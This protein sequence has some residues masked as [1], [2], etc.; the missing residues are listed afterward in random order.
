MFPIDLESLSVG[1][2]VSGS[3]Y[4]DLIPDIAPS[5]S[6]FPAEA[7]QFLPPQDKPPYLLFY[8]I[9]YFIEGLVAIA[10]P[11]VIHPAAHNCID[12]L[13]YFL[14][15][16]VPVCPKHCLYFPAIFSRFFFRGVLLT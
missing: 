15:R 9:P 2:I 1:Y 3:L 13:Y 12:R 14:H 8:I 5:T 6:S 7:F 10:Y 4:T 16:L 11:E